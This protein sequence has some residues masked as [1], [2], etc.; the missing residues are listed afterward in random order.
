MKQTLDELLS[1]PDEQLRAN[2]IRAR[3]KWDEIVK[4][5]QD[6][7]TESSDIMKRLHVGQFWFEDYCG[8]RTPGQQAMVMVGFAYYYTGTNGFGENLPWA[9]KI[10]EAFEISSCSGCVKDH[11]KALAQEYGLID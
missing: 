8:G 5:I 6:D 11:A 7:E 3:E 4:G 2:Y 1:T 9:K 10:V